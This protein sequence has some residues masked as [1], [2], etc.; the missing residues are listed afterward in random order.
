M[1]TLAGVRSLLTLGLV[2]LFHS[3]SCALMAFGQA[4]DEGP[5]MLV[6]D[7]GLVGALLGE[8]DAP[9]QAAAQRT[10]DRL[11]KTRLAAVERICGLRE[12][13][14]RKL[15]L[16]G[17]Q[18]IRRLLDGIREVRQKPGEGNRRD[19]QAEK[20]SLEHQL[21][22]DTFGDRSLFSKV[23][24]STLTEDQAEKFNRH[25]IQLRSSTKKITAENASELELAETW[26]KDAWKMQWMAD[27]SRHGVMAFGKPLE[28]YTPDLKLD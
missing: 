6:T 21:K 23:L 19:A 25:H 12:D 5:T 16:A 14:V 4:T 17:G 26:H 15:E 24:T 10:M 20:M 2:V 7:F 8:R 22:Y 28:V 13:Q 1:K 9:H 11:L 27:A 3:H 18:D